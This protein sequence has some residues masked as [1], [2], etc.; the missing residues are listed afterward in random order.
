MRTIS[1]GHSRIGK[2]QLRAWLAPSAESTGFALALLR[3]LYTDDADIREWLGKGRS[4]F[5]GLTAAELLRA[6]RADE[7]EALLV[8][9]WNAMTLTTPDDYGLRGKV[10]ACP[11]GLDTRMAFTPPAVRTNSTRDASASAKE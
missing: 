4:E 1:E 7:V 9:Q 10:E 5:H 3:D 11:A 2:E 8:R 6:G